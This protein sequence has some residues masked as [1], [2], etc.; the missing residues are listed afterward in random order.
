MPKLV[1]VRVFFCSFLDDSTSSLRS[2]TGF[3]ILIILLLCF[4]SPPPPTKKRKERGVYKQD[5]TMVTD[6]T[7]LGG[8][9]T[10]ITSC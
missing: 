7:S 6:E 9:I 2:Y 3:S 4:L 10:V 5:K 8:N 1:I